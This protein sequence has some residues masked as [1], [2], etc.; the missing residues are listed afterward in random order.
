MSAIEG[1]GREGER[2]K[3]TGMREKKRKEEKE[4]RYIGREEREGEVFGPRLV[5]EASMLR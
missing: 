1:R 5:I 3:G 4:K 2:E